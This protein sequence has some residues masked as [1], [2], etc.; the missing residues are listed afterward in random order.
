MVS[1][2]RISVRSELH[3]LAVLIPYVRSTKAEPQAPEMVDMLTFA[4]LSP[5]SKAVRRS[6]VIWRSPSSDHGCV[7]GR[8]DDIVRS[9]FGIVANASTC[10]L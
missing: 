8:R 4:A 9:R 1:L 6:R 3:P 10:W 5:R 7:P 2:A